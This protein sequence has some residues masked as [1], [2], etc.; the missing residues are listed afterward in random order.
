MKDKTSCGDSVQRQVEAVSGMALCLPVTVF[1][2][3]LKLSKD[4]PL[5]VP[6]LTLDLSIAIPI[7][8]LIDLL[9]EA[10]PFKTTPDPGASTYSGSKLSGSGHGS[11]HH[12]SVF[13]SK[14]LS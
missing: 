13:G 1:S 10:S 6:S 7:G 9:L 14:S 2:D 4:G 8:E 3:K 5:E 11:N 12:I